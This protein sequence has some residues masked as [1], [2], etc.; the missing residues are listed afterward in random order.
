MSRMTRTAVRPP[1]TI[2]RIFSSDDMRHLL[3]A[4]PYPHTATTGAD[5]GPI[6][7]DYRPPEGWQA[8]F[9]RYG[10]LARAPEKAATRDRPASSNPLAVP[11][12]ASQRY[13]TVTLRAV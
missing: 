5:T 6:G 12:L 8:G 3:A 11:V 9:L 13:V 10:P 7:G 1:Q 2:S 4:C